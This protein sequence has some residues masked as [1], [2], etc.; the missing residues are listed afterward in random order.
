MRNASPFKCVTITAL[1][2]ASVSLAAKNES[3]EGKAVVEI[4]R[5]VEIQ[6]RDALSFGR[7]IMLK[8]TGGK[9]RV[10]LDGKGDVDAGRG[11]A[12]D[13]KALHTA[14]RFQLDGAGG[15]GFDIKLST[16]RVPLVLQGS[17]T[18]AAVSLMARITHLRVGTTVIA[19]PDGAG[20][21]A[22]KGSA[23]ALTATGSNFL[24]VAGE[25]AIDGRA[26]MG[27]YEGKYDVTIIHE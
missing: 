3:A 26:T 4:V 14:G 24:T 12:L 10:D 22:T 13:G 17:A 6:F 15:S 7:V 20:E 23:L 27:K 8:D 5:P 19:I 9:V 21:F 18:P 11:L 25:M 16:S 1:T 2:C